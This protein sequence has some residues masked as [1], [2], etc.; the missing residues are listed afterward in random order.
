MPLTALLALQV[1]RTA[2]RRVPAMANRS[3]VV[4]QIDR[5]LLSCGI[6][7]GRYRR[8]KVLPCL[9]TFCQACLATY[10][11]THSLALTCPVCRQTSILPLEGVAGLQTNFFITNLIDVVASQ[12]PT[13]CTSSACEQEEARAVTKCLDCNLY[14][15]DVCTDTHCAMETEVVR[16]GREEEEEAV[17]H[18]VVGIDEVSGTTDS[19]ETP[20]LVCPN[21]YGNALQYYCVECET[22][23]CADC[24]DI[25]HIGH[26]TISLRDAIE[27]QKSELLKL[28]AQVREQEP[29]VEDSIALVADVSTALQKK[30]VEV[31]QHICNAFNE[32][33]KLLDERKAA[34]LVELAE[35][36]S[37][38]QEVLSEQ[39]E[40]LESFL[41]RIRK[42]CDFTAESLSHGNETEILL[43]K[44]E[45]SKKLEE[46]A[47]HKLQFLPEQNEFLLFDDSLL[48]SL[49]K[50]I[51]TIGSLHTTSAVAYETTASGEGLRQTYVGRPSMI[52]VT[53]K[54]RNGELVKLGFAPLT[55]VITGDHLEESVIPTVTD[56][57]NGTYDI[58]YTL[59]QEGKH[60][61]ELKLFDQHIK[62]SPF[63]VGDELKL[64]DQ[65]IGGSL[66]KVGD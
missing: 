32:L 63:K 49:K 21:H 53:T 22:A 59:K 62:G 15:C 10:V 65:H 17:P 37:S 16:E 9:H 45:M 64:F 20:H 14:L 4:R 41:N 31:E 23:V 2:T 28:V 54:D 56:N 42:S 12:Q 52:T 35:V 43:V 55:A 39:K 11:P 46:L 7:L 38:K 24:T 30:S 25:E 13:V 57:R 3:P 18:T 60:R 40:A 34:L 61:L 29:L 51:S 50:S 6:C 58:T 44:K 8:P 36:C 33:C 26:T 48:Q 5:E 47:T 19:D 1:E 66:F 27:E